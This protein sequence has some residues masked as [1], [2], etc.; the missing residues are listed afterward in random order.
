MFLI[1][2]VVQLVQTLS[3]VK[4]QSSFGSYWGQAEMQLQF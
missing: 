3:Q 2:L 1:V 4:T